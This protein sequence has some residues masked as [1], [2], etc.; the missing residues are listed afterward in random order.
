[1]LQ[2]QPSE[3]QPSSN[4]KSLF[5]KVATTATLLAGLTIGGDLDAASPTPDQ[6]RPV[7]S[8][9]DLNALQTPPSPEAIRNAGEILRRLKGIS[10]NRPG[11]NVD[12]AGMRRW[13]LKRAERAMDLCD[14][15]PNTDPTP[16]QRNAIR[17][18]TL[19]ICAQ[20]TR[21]EVAIRRFDQSEYEQKT[22]TRILRTVN[23][24]QDDILRDSP[25]SPLA[26]AAL[27][28]NF[29]THFYLGEEQESLSPVLSERLTE[30]ADSYIEQ[31]PA[32]RDGG[33]LLSKA[34]AHAV[35]FTKYDLA[36]ENFEKLIAKFP[37]DE[38]L[39]DEA[40]AQ[41]D[42][43]NRLGK[44]FHVTGPTL[45]GEQFS[46]D[47]MEG[48]VVLVDFWATWCAPCVREMPHVKELYEKYHDQGFEI[49]GVS[50][51]LSKTRLREFTEAQE[52]PWKQIIF[53]SINER[54]WANPIAELHNV[55]SIPSMFVVDREGNLK[56]FKV[57]GD[58]LERIIKEALEEGAE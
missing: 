8:A 49:V 15:L 3:H 48:K 47:Q 19:G 9:N 4:Q 53:D 57:R 23:T 29:Q 10:Q 31:F 2:N 16:A 1:M 56:A 44:P 42:Q 41:L 22:T 33:E 26:K 45:D 55:R 37:N 52:I 39:T 54:S 50:L 11:E 14:Q 20:A 38:V 46:M 6:D 17:E 25:N 13:N 24:L 51:D 34:G 36:R 7:A 12:I 21:T 35:Y 27:V 32:D 40:Q 43:L 18:L 58:Q 28:A 30:I 5:Q